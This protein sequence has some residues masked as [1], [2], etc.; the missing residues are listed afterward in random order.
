[1]CTVVAP[2]IEQLPDAAKLTVNPDDAVALAAKSGSPYVLSA[3]APNVIVW[4]ALF[5]VCPPAR[6]PVLPKK[7]P[8]GVYTASIVCGE[9]ATVKAAVEALV[10]T[11]LLPLAPSVTGDPK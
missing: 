3:S 4:L 10:A 7:D 6:V 1:M 11:P 8:V 9:P 5:T 2:A